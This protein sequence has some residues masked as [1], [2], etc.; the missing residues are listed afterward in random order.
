MAAIDAVLSPQALEPPLLAARADGPAGSSRAISLARRYRFRAG[1]DVNI[2]N[3]ASCLA[4]LLIFDGRRA[5][6]RGPL[7]R[8]KAPASVIGLIEERR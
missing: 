5:E 1:H 3:I 8:R 7:H 2:S 6:M 4:I